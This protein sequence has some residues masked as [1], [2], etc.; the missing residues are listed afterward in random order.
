[1]YYWQQK[2]EMCSQVQ[3][4]VKINTHVPITQPQTL[5]THNK[6]CS[7]YITVSHLPLKEYFEA[8]LKHHVLEKENIS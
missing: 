7:I 1:M 3:R 6:P 2:P 5:S 4:P 8:N